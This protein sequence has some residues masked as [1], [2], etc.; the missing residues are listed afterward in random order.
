MDITELKGKGYDIDSALIYTGGEDNLFM[1]LS[2]FEKAY[3]KM[4]E[5]LNG[6]VDDNDYQ[7]FSITVHAIKSN[8]RML[9]AFGL[10]DLAEKLEHGTDEGFYDTFDDDLKVFFGLYEKTVND[11]KPFAKSAGESEASA[12]IGRRE[13]I[14]TLKELAEKLDE[15]DDTESARLLKKLRGFL[16]AD[17]AKKQLDKASAYL[18]EFM[19]DEALEA[20]KAVLDTMGD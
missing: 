9:G 8:A 19:Y 6:F 13:A 2:L 10:A 18:D 7:N 4:C 12:L 15:Y 5:Q 17:E 11:I 20:V 1:S 14:R 3:P 16:F